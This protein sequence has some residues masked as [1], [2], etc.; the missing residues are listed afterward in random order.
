MGLGEN[1]IRDTLRAALHLSRFIL[2]D[3]LEYC[4]LPEPYCKL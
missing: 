3:I 1:G 4:N 2:T